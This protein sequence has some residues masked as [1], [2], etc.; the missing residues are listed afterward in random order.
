MAGTAT[1]NRSPIAIWFMILSISIATLIGTYVLFVEA[2]PPKRIVIA[3]GSKEGAYHRFA[4]RYRDLLKADGITLE[5]RETK[6]SVENLQLLQDDDSEVRIGFVQTGVAD[7]NSAEDLEALATL[8][9]EPLWIFY[10][11]T[12]LVDRLTQ[13]DGKR[14]AIGPEGSG[15]RVVASQLL[16][17][18]GIDPGN[19]EYVSFGGNEAAT[20]L[21]QRELDAAFFVAGIDAAYIPRLLKNPR[22]HLVELAQAA[23]YAR[24]FRFLSTVTVHEG[25]I[26]LEHDIPSSDRALIGPSAT[27][28]AHKSLHPALIPLFLRVVSRVHQ[29]GDLLSN[30]NEFPTPQLTDLPLSADADRYFRTGPP[31]LQRFLPF[32]LASLLDRLKIMI[33]PLIMLMMPLFRVAPP[34]VRWQTRRKIYMWYAE[35]RKIDQKTIDGMSTDEAR[36]CVDRL[37]R[38][39]QQIAHVGVPLSY[40]EEYYNLRLHLDLVRSRVRSIAQSVE[41]SP[42]TN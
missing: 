27:L 13:L 11:G 38:L 29:K 2:P 17:A 6:G 30:V 18:N 37:H 8:Y 20:A 5:L 33:I 1:A 28:V 35:L 42:S 22:I 40:M 4:E 24:Q 39:E 19:D 41:S 3:T 31:V 23:A 34:L 12:E 21:E 25:L 10:R 15:T 9:R 16:A 36:Q 26:D 7:P 14:I 32:W